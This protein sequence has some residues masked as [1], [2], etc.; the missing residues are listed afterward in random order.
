MRVPIVNLAGQYHACAAP[1]RSAIERVLSASSF[2]R[3]PE[4]E[5]FERQFAN[6]IGADHAI[7][8]ACGGDALYLTL[9][10]LG[11]GPGHE[12]IV[13][14]YTYIATAFAV[15]RTGA[16]PVFVDCDKTYNIDPLLIPEAITE[17]TRA[18]IPVHLTGQSVDM[19]AVH[20][21]AAELLVVE[22][23]AQAAGAT[24]R[25][26]RCGSMGDV[27]CF[28][29][30]PSKNLGGCGDGG[31]VVT[32]DDYVMAEVLILRNYGQT[33]K[34]HHVKVGVNSLL[35]GL[36][37]ALLACKLPRLDEWNE[38]R[39]VLAAHYKNRLTGC[40][41]VSGCQ[42]SV[43]GAEHVY[44]L[45]TIEAPARD[46]LQKFLAEREIQTA[47]HYPSPIHKQPAYSDVYGHL[48][49]PVA[50]HLAKVSLSLPMC[51]F[52]TMRQIEYV[53]RS[54][55]EFARR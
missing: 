31:M 28:S 5:R 22:D 36:Q 21:S 41:A 26:R 33:E 25:G 49:F 51:P 46:A 34:Y 27:G 43:V 13:P 4:L 3:G 15:S 37:A 14:I 7:G 44:H 20:D 52:T 50:E 47:I 42:E 2:V 54:I 29:F 1:M 9:R 45:F 19:D 8:V 32:N 40:P 39:R 17:R 53:C 12:V 10:A 23:A 11:I 6:Y 55:W 35:D 18:I 24:Y 48:S 30:Y 38:K 16:T